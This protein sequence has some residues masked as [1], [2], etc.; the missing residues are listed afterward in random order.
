MRATGSSVLLWI[1]PLR[2]A[3]RVCRIAILV[4]PFRL[5]LGGFDGAEPGVAALAGGFEDNVNLFQGAGA[6][7]GIETMEGEN[8]STCEGKI[9]FWLELTNR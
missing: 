7:F 1:T 6:G 3:V 5:L 2:A 8:V 4:E 9:L